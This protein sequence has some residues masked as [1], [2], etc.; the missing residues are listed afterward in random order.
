MS[1][2]NNPQPVERDIR[3]MV[4]DEAA[5]ELQPATERAIASRLLQGLRPVR[6]LPSRATLAASFLAIFAVIAA[7]FAGLIGTGGAAEMTATQLAGILGAVVVGAGL[8]SVSLSGEMSPGQRRVVHPGIMTAGVL[9]ALLALII[10]LF[11]WDGGITQGWHCFGSGFV[12]SLPAVGLVLLV[13]RKGT[14]LAWGAVGASAGL[15]GG[16]VGM[17]AIHVGC[18]MLS[19][20]HMAIGHVTIPL[21]CSVAGFLTGRALPYVWPAQRAGD[22]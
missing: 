3:A 18:T 2:S 6:P 19:A 16:L 5:A 13:I 9:L 17:A 14:P 22:L 21:A 1:A 20:P 10:G 7:A 11:P 12:F 4:P 15:L 8:A